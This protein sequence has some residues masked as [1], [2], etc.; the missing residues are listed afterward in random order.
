MARGRLSVI[1]LC[2]ILISFANPAIGDTSRNCRL[3]VD[4]SFD[5]AVSPAPPTDQTSAPS[6]DIVSGDVASNAQLLT[7]VAR[8][9]RLSSFEPTAPDG[10]KVVMGFA[11]GKAVFE[12]VADRGTAGQSAYLFQSS[13][14]AGNGSAGAGT[15]TFLGA[16]PV[17]FD[18]DVSEVR[19]H[20]PLNLLSR[21]APTRRG[22]VVAGLA[23]RTKRR[24]GTAGTSL[25]NV[26]AAATGDRASSNSTYRLGSPSCVR[27]GV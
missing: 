15:Y 2:A 23:Q 14:A 8:V 7:V 18:E 24:A 27:V 5:D 16:V 19:A 9:R 12:V 21:H 17:V 3:L 11:L 25:H 1:P 26:N 20:V 22:T 6:L 10:F 13:G 4:P